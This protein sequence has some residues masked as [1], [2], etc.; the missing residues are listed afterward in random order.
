MLQIVQRA[1][2]K[3]A[4]RLMRQAVGRHQ[5]KS[6]PTNYGHGRSMV[7]TW[8]GYGR[9]DLVKT[10]L[11]KAQNR[12]AV[13]LIGIQGGGM[14]YLSLRGL[15]ANNGPWRVKCLDMQHFQTALCLHMR[16]DHAQ[17]LGITSY[18]VS[19]ARL[20]VREM[21]KITDQLVHLRNKHVADRLNKIVI[22]ARTGMLVK[23]P[24]EQY[25]VH[26]RAYP[27]KG[28]Q[29][30]GHNPQSWLLYVLNTF[31]H[32]V[33]AFDLM[34]PSHHKHIGVGLSILFFEVMYR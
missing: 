16:D 4:V 3:S 31:A 5:D 22:H 21:L 29:F 26:M 13:S 25:M 30:H 15:R 24:W 11:A 33:D 27:F 8:S 7:G 2:D 19:R 32:G 20:T 1:A 6:I 12:C 14:G 23:A 17:Q 9:I 34:N 18:L 10:Y 28:L